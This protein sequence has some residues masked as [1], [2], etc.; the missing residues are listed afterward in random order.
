MLRK[1][2]PM[3]IAALLLTLSQ[4]TALAFNQAADQP[5]DAEFQEM[6]RMREIEKEQS[7]QRLLERENSKPEPKR[8]ARIHRPGTGPTEGDASTVVATVELTP[9]EIKNRDWSR[10]VAV[11]GPPSGGGGTTSRE[12]GFTENQLNWLLCGTILVVGL[13]WWMTRRNETEGETVQTW[14][15]GSSDSNG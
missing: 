8:V 9:E 14:L 12:S 1:Y 3:V 15:P 11:A 10:V 2:S 6:I 13:I 5:S 4:G 7:R